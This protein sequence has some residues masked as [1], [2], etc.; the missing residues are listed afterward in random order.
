[1]KFKIAFVLAILSVN[2]FAQE[3]L[4]TLTT[5]SSPAASILGMQPS[6]ILKPKSYR[7]LEAALYS[8][9]SDDNGNSIIPNDFGLEFMPYWA[10][11]HSLTLEDYLYPKFNIDQL[12]RN[13]ALSLASTQQFLLQDSTKTKSIAIGYRTSVFFGNAKDKE[14]ITALVKNLTEN[15]RIGSFILLE[16]EK[17][18]DKSYTKKE[19]YLRD[20]RDVLTDRIYKELKTKSKKEAETIVEN[21]YNETEALPFDMA[22]IDDFFIAFGDLIEKHVGGSYDEFKAYIKNR[23]GL[24]IDFACAVHVNFPD[25]NFNFSEVPKYSV[26]L[27][28]SYNFS[29]KLDFLKATATLRY[30]HYYKDYFEKYFPAANVFDNNIDYGMAL[31]GN[32]KK[33]SVELEAT[34]RQSKSLIKSGFDTSGN[35]L[36]RKE[37]SGDFQYIATFSYRLTEQIALSYQFGSAFKPTF[38]VN[39]GTLISLLSLN[40]GFG[41]PNKSDVTTK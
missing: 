25:N 4:N 5:P 28:P 40:L 26:W 16:L 13:S 22:K 15:Q 11:N 23:Q 32:F 37:S 24:L 30:E 31:S 9:F 34:G 41:G 6:V 39:N 27:T 1:M 20:V 29:N 10:N 3:K 8:N 14:N 17:L 12:F 19:D 21:I 33:F 35:T 7:A 36:Y 38:N 2:C 18:K